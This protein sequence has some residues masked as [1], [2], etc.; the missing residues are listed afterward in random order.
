MLSFS[1]WSADR[2]YGFTWAVSAGGKKSTLLGGALLLILT[3][4]KKIKVF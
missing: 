1:P 2:L 4:V 3:F